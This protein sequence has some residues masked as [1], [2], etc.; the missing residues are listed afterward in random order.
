MRPQL[1]AILLLALACSGR[2][3]MVEPPPP[4]PFCGDGVVNPQNGEECEG[5][6]LNGA[7]CQSLGFDDGTVTCSA[8]KVITALCVKRC[9]NGLLDPGEGCDGDAGVPA[10]GDFGYTACSATC[11]VDRSHCVTTPFQAAN[12]A[13][14]LMKGG[15]SA[16]TDLAPKGLGDLVVAV[17]SR[18]RVESSP[19]TV[20]R[21]FDLN[22]RK[23]TFGNVPIQAIGQALDVIALN[24]DGTLDRY[25]YDAGTFGLVHFPDAG[26]SGPILGELSQGEIAT[27]SCD[28]GELHVFGAQ[29]TRSPRGGGVSAFGDVD[30]DGR[31]DVLSVNGQSLEVHPAPAFGQVDAGTLPVALSSLAT[32]DFDGDGDLDLAGISGASVKLL[33]NQGNG[34]ADRLT[35]PAAMAARLH[36]ADLDLDGRVDLVW[37]A[38]D[39]AQVRRNQGS[40][41]FAPFEATFRVGAGTALSFSVGDVDGDGDL[42]LVSTRAGA[43]TDSSVSFV[44]V[45]RVR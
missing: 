42:D 43:A 39:R 31:V 34:F 37:E 40:W 16:I 14:E 35:I 32:G 22:T 20:E 26:C 9:G 23:F 45:N 24:S 3:K 25:A 28:G 41:V 11:T 27:T 10:C 44:Q 12:G 5:S 2:V 6:D 19:Y 17:P 33:E 4:D 13:L 7:S 1:A 38:G 8:C 29:L 18:A 15:P 21:G 36:T 30:G